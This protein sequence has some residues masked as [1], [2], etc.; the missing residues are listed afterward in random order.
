MGR[1]S[2]RGFPRQ[3]RFAFIAVCLGLVVWIMFIAMSGA[4]GRKPASGTSQVAKRANAKASR[5]LESFQRVSGTPFLMAA[6]RSSAYYQRSSLASYSSGTSDA[7]NY[8][9]L[10]MENQSFR[11]LLPTNDYLISEAAALPEASVR[12]Q[13][14]SAGDDDSVG[15]RWWLF[16]V[17]KQDTNR[18]G[19]LDEKDLHTL[20]VSDAGGS[21]YTELIEGIRKQYGRALRDPDTLVVIYESGGV[22]RVSLIDLPKRAVI[23]TKPLPDLGPDLK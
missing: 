22:K 5:F 23:S 18:D 12:T 10:D 13:V 6:I 11:R 2:Q 4:F 7:H 1:E 16:D 21:G 8:V 19:E 15:V 17:V 20:G 14:K 9:F 3:F